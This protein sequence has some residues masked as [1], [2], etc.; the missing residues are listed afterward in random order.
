M[1]GQHALGIHIGHDRGAALVSAGGL[2]AQIAEERLDRKKHSNSLEL[3]LKSIAAVLETGGVRAS[4]LGA[5]G[6]SGTN[7]EMERIIPLLREEVRDALD[8]PHLRVVGVGHHDCH[9]WAA[10]GT[11]DADDALVVVADGSGD[12]VGHRLE[13][14]SVYTASGDD[15]TLVDRRLQDFGL[16][17]ITRRNSFALPYMHES[18]RQKQISLGHKYEQFT[19]LCGFGQREAGKTMGLAAY[20]TSL[21]ETPAPVIGD[22]QFSLTYES[23]LTEIDRVWRASG[24]PWHRFLRNRAADIAATG[25]QLL[26]AYLL[27]LLNALNPVGKHHTLCAAGGVFL[28]CQLNGRILDQTRFRQIH[29]VPAAGDDGL[30]IGAAFQAFKQTFGPVRRGGG[31][32][33]FLGRSYGPPTISQELGSFGLTAEVLEESSL[34]DRLAADLVD[35]KIIGLLRGRS[36]MGPRALC[37]RSILADPRVPGMKDRLNQL[38]GR[39]LFRP[40]APVV[41]EEDQFK[42]FETEHLSRYMLLATRLRPPYQAMLPAV[43][44]ADGSSRVQAVAARQEPFV[45]AL[46]RAFETRTGYPI[47]LNTSFNLAGDPIVESPRDAILTYLASGLDVLVMEGFYVHG[48]VALGAHH[49]V[50]GR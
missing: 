8:A 37:H 44:H 49:R 29:V 22:L 34:A 45:H 32:L 10:Y 3:P 21:I 1:A 4:D 26:E 7:F 48:K 9:A 46:L 50:G 13:A 6:I 12:I 35:G 5:V 31:A 24:E 15:V 40:F 28:N 18:D 38:K 19:Y 2:V 16:A 43:V 23:G 42:F 36:E 27:T 25:Q 30:C 39:E 41:T 20:G 11:A 14:E 33:P 17:R 47:L